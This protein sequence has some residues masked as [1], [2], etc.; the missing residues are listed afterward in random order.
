MHDV[1]RRPRQHAVRLERSLARSQEALHRL[2]ADPV[3]QRV[4]EQADPEERAEDV[5]RLE[6][7]GRRR[8]LLEQRL[9][10]VAGQDVAGQPV[11]DLR[12]V[13]VGDVGRDLLEVLLGDLGGRLVHDLLQARLV[14]SLAGRKV[15]RRWPIVIRSRG[16]SSV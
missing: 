12:Q 5:E 8:V 7:A 9:D 11:Q 3:G 2:A 6:G 1:V 16:R 15:V 13:E 4:A 14:A 10:L